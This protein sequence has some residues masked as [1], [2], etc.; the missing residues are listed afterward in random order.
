M[1]YHMDVIYSLL[2]EGKLHAYQLIFVKQTKLHNS[3]VV[4]TIKQQLN[5]HQNGNEQLFNMQQERVNR[6]SPTYSVS[7][8]IAKLAM[9]TCRRVFGLHC[10]GACSVDVDA[11][12]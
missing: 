9:V 1:F 4:A 11:S 6:Q 10:V 8:V 3:R 7:Y 5:V 12:S 2:N